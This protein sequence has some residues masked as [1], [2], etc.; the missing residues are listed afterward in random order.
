MGPS[1][2]RRMEGRGRKNARS[3]RGRGGGQRGSAGIRCARR[4]RPAECFVLCW[5]NSRERSCKP[6]KAPRAEGAARSRTDCS[7]RGLFPP[8]TAA[9]DGEAQER[10]TDGAARRRRT[11]RPRCRSGDVYEMIS[12]RM[13]NHVRCA[14]SRGQSAF[15]ID[16][17]LLPR[18][19]TPTVSTTLT[20]ATRCYTC[21]TSPSRATIL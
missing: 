4:D 17:G 20:V 10:K 1:V 6:G 14:G 15:L 9:R 18:Q 21:S 19:R 3:E 7:S 2:R 12:W 8:E 13:N 16:R 11:R 5:R